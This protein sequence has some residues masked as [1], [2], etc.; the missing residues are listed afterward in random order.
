MPVTSTEVRASLTDALELDLIGPRPRRDASTLG[1]LAEILPQAP[2]AWY[3]TGF[4]IP[5][6]TKED[7]KVDPQADDDLDVI[8][9]SAGADEDTNTDPPSGRQRILP[10]S[11]GLS[12][13]VPPDCLSIHLTVRWGD[14]HRDESTNPASWRR[15]HKEQSLPLDLAG[16]RSGRL[17]EYNVPNHPGLKVHVLHRPIKLSSESGIP[18]GSKAV[19]IFLVNRRPAIDNEDRRDEACTFQTELILTTP[20][21]F[22]GRPDLRSLSG[23]KDWDERVADLQYRDDREYATGHNVATSAQIDPDGQCRQVSTTWLPCTEV[24]RVAPS[25]LKQIDSKI[26]R[27]DYLST[28]EDPSKLLPLVNAYREWIQL[29]AAIPLSSERRSV[30]QD[31]LL[32]AQAAAK[33][34]EQGITSLNNPANLRAFQLANQAMALSA[35]RRAVIDNRDLNT[36]VPTWRPFQLAFLLLNLV[37]IAE[38]TNA[39]R[40]IVDLLFFPTGGGKTEAYLGLSAFTLVLRRLQNPGIGSAGVTVLMRYTLRLL[41]LDQL[42]R[43]STLICALEEIRAKDVSV[44][45]KWPFEIGL[46]VGSAATPNKMGGKGQ[47][48]DKETCARRRTLAFLNKSSNDAPLPIEDC[49]WCGTKFTAASYRL[50]PNKDNPEEL[51]LRCASP[52][53]AFTGDRYLPILAVDEMIYR[54][55]PCFLIATVDKFAALPYTGQVGYFFGNVS[56]V[57]NNGFYGAMDRDG[58]GNQL[59]GGCLPPPDLIIQDELHL[60]SGP[61][62]TLVGL[63]E[64]ALE[65]LCSRGAGNPIRPKIIASTATVRKADSQIRALF[66]RQS[67]DI[68]PPPGPNRRDSFFAETVPPAKSAARL[69]VGVAAQGRSPKVVQLRVY[70]ALLSAG[71][72][73]YESSPDAADPYIT[74]LGYFN[75]LRELGGTRRLVEDEVYSQLTNRASRKRI[76][77]AEED[78]FADRKIAPFPVELT[79][80]ASSTEVAKAKYLLSRAFKEKDHVDVALATNMISV[81]LDITRLGLLVVYGQPKTTAEY[82]QATSRVGRDKDKP[83][84]VVTILNPHKPRDR[85]HY[86]RF[87]AYHQTFYRAVEA[88]SVTPYSPRALDRGLAAV[89]VSLMRHSFPA[90]TEALGVQNIAQVR[91]QAKP[92]IA[93]LAERAKDHRSSGEWDN[94]GDAQALSDRVARRCQVLLD[95]WQTV[96]LTFENNGVPLQYN[97]YEYKANNHLLRDFLSDELANLT[98]SDWR[99]QFRA[100]RSLRDVEA[101]SNIHVTEADGSLDTSSARD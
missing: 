99:M 27:M 8:P 52:D 94:A 73:A 44:L 63:Y 93:Y 13:L 38:P 36:L 76:F 28:L 43:A 1:D 54:R 19:S 79:S 6:E 20:S 18:T 7:Q 53:C 67:V 16:T 95:L 88:S 2:R 45:G 96:D 33:R 81:G 70:L 40:D 92:L 55:L 97:E 49:P 101:V 62:G 50:L 60:I 69:Y 91:S 15:Q 23:N 17:K 22:L 30:S 9:E 46:W 90:M 29:Q 39:D 61:L 68:F 4:L 32:Q 34:I 64:A 31:L 26:F 84:L 72:K 80:R 58:Q 87:S 75:A 65:K 59:P 51:R 71:Q 100:N 85:S 25:E 82:I 86:E 11:F 10:S 57:D 47:P 3:L 37:S 98:R 5:I 83:G 77:P 74:L 56:R 14:Y 24:E 66:G 35:R 89:L 42:G 48:D 78:I 41:T 12:V 21:G